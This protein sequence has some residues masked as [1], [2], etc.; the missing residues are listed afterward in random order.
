MPIILAF[1]LPFNRFIF[2]T[3]GCMLNHIWFAMILLAVLI[4][5]GND[6]Y[7]EVVAPAPNGQNQQNKINQL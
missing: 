3:G 5:A 7:Q 2:K 6:F 1:I 4:A